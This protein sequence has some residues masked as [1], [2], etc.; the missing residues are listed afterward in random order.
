MNEAHRLQTMLHLN[1]KVPT[2]FVTGSIDFERIDIP[3]DHELRLAY[4]HG[5]ATKQNINQ[6]YFVAVSYSGV[7]HA[8][9]CRTLKDGISSEFLS[10][11]LPHG[12]KI[13][14]VRH[15]FE[16]K[17]EV[18][19]WSVV[20]DKVHGSKGLKLKL[21]PKKAKQKLA[22]SPAGPMVIRNSQF[23]LRGSLTLT[24]K[25]LLKKKQTLSEC[26]DKS[27]NGM[28]DLQVKLEPEFK[29]CYSNFLHFYE[30]SDGSWRRRWAKLD[31]HTL[32][33]WLTPESAERGDAPLIE[34]DMKLCINPFVGRVTS[35]VCPRKHSFSIILASYPDK[36]ANRVNYILNKNY[37]SVTR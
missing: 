10:F 28:I 12:L 11:K 5:L 36:T 2:D 27:L 14:G 37:S 17:I 4:S 32:K 29:K 30:D 20:E 21:T 35:D 24:H 16:V 33:C 31:G 1:P 15:E 8:S 19:G 3:I 13:C 25:N 34:I 18:Y 23:T 26:T 9:E 22:P 6:F 7:V